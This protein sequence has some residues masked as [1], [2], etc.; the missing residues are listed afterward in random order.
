LAIAVRSI[1]FRTEPLDKKNIEMSFAFM[2][3]AQTIQE[4]EN[5]LIVTA[6]M[7]SGPVKVSFLAE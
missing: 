7:Q 2:R 1:F 5:P 6:P 4:D 3:D